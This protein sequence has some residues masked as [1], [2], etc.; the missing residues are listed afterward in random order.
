MSTVSC[1]MTPLKRRSKS[2]DDIKALFHQEH[3]SND[4]SRPNTISR[5]HSFYSGTHP[6][7]YSRLAN[8]Y[9]WMTVTALSNMTTDTLVEDRL[10]QTIQLNNLPKEPIE[11]NPH[12]FDF[13][14]KDSY[15]FIHYRKS[16]TAITSATT[17]KLVERLTREMDHEFL[18]NFFL[19]FR[20]FTTPIKL[21]KL[22]ITRFRW[23]L[24]ENT[25]ERQWIR[26]RTFTV[27]RYWLTHFWAFDFIHSH[28]LRFMLCTFLT[29]LHTHTPIACNQKIVQSLRKILKRQRGFHRHY[30]LLSPETVWNHNKDPW[31]LHQFT[32]KLLSL[33]NHHQL[34]TV[35]RY[36]SEVIAQQFCLI[37]RDMLQTV[38][39]N[40][41]IE[42]RWRKK[43]KKTSS[44]SHLTHL[45]DLQGVDLLI[46]YFNKSCQWVAS[47]IVRC[48]LLGIRVRLI[49][50]FIRIA[51]KC[52]QHR[53]Y[54][55]LMQILL[56]LQSP[57][58]TRLVKTWEKVD[59]DT[60]KTLNQ[61][62]ELAK[63]FKN[64]KYIRECMTK[65]TEELT[66][67]SVVECVL[68]Q[69]L[70]EPE[71]VNGCIPFLGKIFVTVT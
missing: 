16:D 29:Q 62:K 41:L 36:R 61:L 67:S 7:E 37:E 51:Y 42:L 4:L 64:W 43:E 13:L 48:P 46:E 26:I 6:P 44:F 70:K 50:K 65:A 10:V 20:Q 58:V 39:W 22:L 27:I 8:I 31:I 54:S 59:T 60:K 55:T 52:Y 33:V 25:Q 30:E 34:P 14:W 63:P 69:S 38:S 2:L 40:E 68:T 66:A 24:L 49:E 1:T 9:G 12:M 11:N 3:A 19:T 15:H 5:R 45:E 57:T 23:T 32:H 53:N 56:G 21:C 17:E 47:E 71:Y 35:L 18:M 28:T